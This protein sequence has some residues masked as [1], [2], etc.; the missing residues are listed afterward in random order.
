[1]SGSDTTESKTEPQSRLATKRLTLF[2]S[3]P[4]R[5]PVSN[6]RLEEV[7]TS[8]WGSN[9]TTASHHRPRGPSMLVM[10]QS[11]SSR[12]NQ[13]PRAHGDRISFA[14]T[15]ALL[16]RNAIDNGHPSSAR[17]RRSEEISVKLTTRIQVGGYNEEIVACWHPS[18]TVNSL[19]I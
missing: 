17:S 16:L 2:S 18:K 11:S 9:R 5:K 4:E 8:G 12:M 10:A 3:K 6:N 7:V 13:S 15:Q 19:S 1:M 14:D